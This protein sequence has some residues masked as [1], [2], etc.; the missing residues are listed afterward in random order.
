ML[1]CAESQLQTNPHDKESICVYKFQTS[2]LPKPQLTWMGSPHE[3][4][5]DWPEAGSLWNSTKSEFDYVTSILKGAS[6]H[7]NASSVKRQ[8][9]A[10]N[11][12]ASQAVLKVLEEQQREQLELQH[13]ETEANRKIA[14]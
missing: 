1:T 2:L 3:D 13:L 5:P 8:E 10:A 12:A 14:A 4:E 6:E 9:A 11:A 7:S